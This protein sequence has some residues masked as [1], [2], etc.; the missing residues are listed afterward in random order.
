MGADTG[1]GLVDNPIQREVHTKHPVFPASGIKGAIKQAL[2]DKADLKDYIDIALGKDSPDEASAVTFTDATLVAFPV[3]SLK[4]TFLYICSP[5]SIARFIRLAKLADE[6]LDAKVPESVSGETNRYLTSS[7][8]IFVKSTDNQVGKVSVES[9]VFEAKVDNDLARLAGFLAD[10]LFTQADD[11]F[12]KKLRKSLVMVSNEDFNYFV[13]TNT[14]VEPHVRI[15][16]ET[17]VAED[18][19]LFYV[20]HLPPESILA[21]L[22]LSSKAR[23]KTQ[24]KEYDS[25]IKILNQ[26]NKLIDKKTFQFGGNYTTGRGLTY[27]AVG[28][29]ENDH[30]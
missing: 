2:L 10:R 14:I 30:D 12:S 15:N 9:F 20:E 28:R 16:R 17:G 1:I 21:G 23:R 13:G 25:A 8:E 7:D 29:G 18:G 5:T 4:D 26:L 6:G 27:I 24:P 11:Y 22:V 19:A 3:R